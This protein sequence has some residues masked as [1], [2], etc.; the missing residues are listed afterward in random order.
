MADDARLAEVEE[1]S[2][3]EVNA[4]SEL[5]FYIVVCITMLVKHC[6][7]RDWMRFMSK[8]TSQLV[9]LY[10]IAEYGSQEVSRRFPMARHDASRA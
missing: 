3:P 8:M 10:R 1:G 7:E 9:L 2:G 5:R 6:F 4:A